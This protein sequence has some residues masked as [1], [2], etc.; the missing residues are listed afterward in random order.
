MQLEITYQEL[1]K[2]AISSLYFLVA[3]LGGV[4][5]GYLL[6]FVDGNNNF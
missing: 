4:Y 2:L 5:I 1:A 6:G 3:F